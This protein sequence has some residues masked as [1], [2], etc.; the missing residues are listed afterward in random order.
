M[1]RYHPATDNMRVNGDIVE[2]ALRV[3][4]DQ[5]ARLAA[6]VAELTGSRFGVLIPVR[7]GS[8]F[9]HLADA[10]RVTR[11]CRSLRR[12]WQRLRR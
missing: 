7:V 6:R 10:G 2:I 3:P 5:S 9:R 4:A 1:L 11:R 12:S 8:L